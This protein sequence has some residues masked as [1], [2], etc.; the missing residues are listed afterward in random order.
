MTGGIF[1]NK[2]KGRIEISL[3][4]QN[5]NIVNFK[6]KK[7]IKWNYLHC[8][9]KHERLLMTMNILCKGIKFI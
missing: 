7:I 8:P 4:F 3:L 5:A 6:G 1:P 2:E 9:S